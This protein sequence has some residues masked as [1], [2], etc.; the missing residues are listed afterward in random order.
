[1][2]SEISPQ[3]VAAPFGPIDLA[4][5]A[6]RGIVDLSFI[7]KQFL[8]MVVRSLGYLTKEPG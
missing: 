7:L 6:E 3:D 2:S 5:I 8:V 4:H 1:M